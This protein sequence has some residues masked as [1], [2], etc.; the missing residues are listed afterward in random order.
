MRK[1]ISTEDSKKTSS[2][3]VG[4]HPSKIQPSNPEKRRQCSNKISG[5]RNTYH[6]YDDEV[7]GSESLV[8]GRCYM[9]V[10]SGS[11]LGLERSRG[12]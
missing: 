6:L 2:T 1:F 9:C 7:V 8:V 5:K 3:S 10:D 12:W 4:L 11:V